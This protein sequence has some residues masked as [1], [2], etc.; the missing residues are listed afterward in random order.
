LTCLLSKLRSVLN[1][2]DGGKITEK[3]NV[4]GNSKNTGLIRSAYNFKSQGL[5]SGISPLNSVCLNKISIA[6]SGMSYS[7]QKST[8]IK[9]ERSE[10]LSL[11]TDNLIDNNPALIAEEVELKQKKLVKLAEKYGFNSI[12][13]HK[14]QLLLVRSL[15]FRL[16]AVNMMKSKPGSQTPGIDN[17]IFDKSEI[18][19]SYEA[20][21]EYLR[22]ITYHPN[23]Y[24]P[25]P[26]KRVGITKPGK[27]ETEKRPL[28]IP[29]VKDRALQTLIN[30][31][32]MPLVEATSDIDSYGFRPYRD[33]KMAVSAVRMQLKSLDLVTQEK[34]MKKRFGKTGLAQDTQL[35]EDKWI[36]DA[37]I[38]C[39]FDN[40]S[41]EWLLTNLFLHPK[42]KSFVEK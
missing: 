8:S 26:I 3:A 12:K 42:L 37:D 1:S 4:L 7:T 24:Y 22:D 21:V 9:V 13:V 15:A 27:S 28:G 31:V 6:L 35:N 33:C 32:L 25:S 10:L 5:T 11:S 18:K 23:K 39:L 16:Q 2:L 14:F 30:L 29:T 40:I 19:K 20:L 41:H 36:L 34:Y 17:E 38:K